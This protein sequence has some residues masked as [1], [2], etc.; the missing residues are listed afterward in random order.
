M[1]RR[2]FTVATV[3][4]HQRNHLLMAS[5]TSNR[6]HRILLPF[7]LASVVMFNVAHAVRAPGVRPHGSAAR[8]FA[9]RRR[10]RRRRFGD[11]Q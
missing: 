11:W 1:N 4:S 8:G 9:R 6:R 10:L 3:F 2:R 5:R 7:V